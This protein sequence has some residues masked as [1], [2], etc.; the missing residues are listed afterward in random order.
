VGETKRA[1]GGFARRGFALSVR[2]DRE[3]DA[4]S[5]FT[6]LT[7]GRL[8]LL[9]SGRMSSEFTEEDIERVVRPAVR[10]GRREDLWRARENPPGK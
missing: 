4:P 9:T 6:G 5:R 1:E 10:A 8:S 2:T 7:D 3:E